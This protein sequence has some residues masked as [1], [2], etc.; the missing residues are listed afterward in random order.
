MISLDRQIPCIFRATV[1]YVRL[2]SA[3]PCPLF[4]PHLMV[5]KDLEVVSLEDIDDDRVIMYA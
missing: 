2:D 4:Y 1:T 5:R 3:Y